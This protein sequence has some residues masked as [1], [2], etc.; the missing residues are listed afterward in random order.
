MTISTATYGKQQEFMAVAELMRRGFD[1]YLTLVDNKGIDCILRIDESRYLDIQIKAR[2]ANI[3]P[4]N[5]GYYPLLAVPT[6]RDNHFF[7]FYS[8]AVSKYWVLPATDIIRLAEEKGSCVNIALSGSNKGK[9]AVRVTGLRN[10][11]PILKK[12][13]EQYRGDKGFAL[14]K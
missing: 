7:I 11:E 9:Y 12:Q 5:F 4:K 2:S 10:G 13:F 3:N 1:V 14:L 8:D 6:D